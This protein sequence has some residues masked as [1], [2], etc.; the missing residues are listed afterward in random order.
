MTQSNYKNVETGRMKAVLSHAHAKLFSKA[1]YLGLGIN[2]YL[3]QYILCT[4]SEGSDKTVHKHS[5]VR[6]FSVHIY[7]KCK[8]LLSGLK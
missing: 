4:N 2:L 8:N 1:R 6:V 5:L 3:F 7:Y